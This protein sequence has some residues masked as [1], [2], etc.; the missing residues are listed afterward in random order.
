MV[1]F[2]EHVSIIWTFFIKFK[3]IWQFIGKWILLFFVLI[4]I[5]SNH[6]LK[7]AM[8]GHHEITE[9]E[10]GSLWVFVILSGIVTWAFNC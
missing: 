6:G 10:G 1:D 9:E 5:S 4:I 7:Q 8:W 3:F 2:I